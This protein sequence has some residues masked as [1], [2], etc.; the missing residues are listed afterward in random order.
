[1]RIIISVCE[2]ILQIYLQ[3]YVINGN[4]IMYE[5]L[6]LRLSATSSNIFLCVQL[7]WSL[8]SQFVS[9]IFFIK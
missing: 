1:M 8:F 4:L 3:F 5:A 7:S 6:K 2:I 9:L